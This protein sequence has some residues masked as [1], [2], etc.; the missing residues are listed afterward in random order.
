MNGIEPVP[1]D[2]PGVM[3]RLLG[4]AR[5][6]H[7][8][9]EIRNRL[10][11][12]RLRELTPEDIDAPLARDRV[13]RE[14]AMPELEKLYAM[15]TRH[16]VRDGDITE[17]DRRDLAHLRRV[18]GLSEEDVQRIE[19][20]LLED[21]Y[22]TELRRAVGDSVLTDQEKQ[23]LREL[24]Q[25]LRIPESVARAVREEEVSRVWARVFDAAVV[26]RRLSADEERYL[27]ELAA[28]LGV[29][30]RMD[31]ATSH[32]LDRFRLL[33]RIEQGELPVLKV[34]VAL[35][36]G[37][38]AHAAVTAERRVSSSPPRPA[39]KRRV[40]LGRV[41]HWELGESVSAPDRAGWTS[42]GSGTL[43]I[44]GHRLLFAG[45]RTPTTV[46][47]ERIERFTVYRDGMLLE[48]EGEQEQLFV[49]AGDSEIVATVLSVLVQRA[50]S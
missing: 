28:N 22:R 13:T 47:L 30:P 46:E 18:L 27:A 36:A 7:A 39:D 37:E 21:V 8:L 9:V 31:R 1:F 19:R 10:A 32:D 35:E 3:E 15:V 26:D 44:T 40:R 17:Q 4:H 12:T 41:V 42:E 5:R 24:A 33:W 20:E 38:Q 49:T 45:A 14:Q 23:R 34:D 6:R 2:P 50:R 48:I 11:T 16:L 25:R 29:Q 43:V